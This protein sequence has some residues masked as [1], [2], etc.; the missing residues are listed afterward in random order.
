[1]KKQVFDNYIYSDVIK[2]SDF[3]YFANR[4]IS[5]P[6]FEKTYDDSIN[7]FDY[8]LS[9][10]FLENYDPHPSIHAKMNV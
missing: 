2:N 3:V 9:D 10:F 6:F 5:S 4:F 1:M 8:K 7:I